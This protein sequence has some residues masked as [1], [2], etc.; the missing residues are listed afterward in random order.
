MQ[1]LIE[2][3]PKRRREVGMHLKFSLTCVHTLV[4]LVCEKY[5]FSHEK[6]T[7]KEIRPHHKNLLILMSVRKTTLT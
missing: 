1:S 7:S 5:D 3:V 4:V 6:I 2:V